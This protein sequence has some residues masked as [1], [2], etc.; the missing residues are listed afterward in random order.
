MTLSKPESQTVPA[1]LARALIAY[2]DNAAFTDADLSLTYGQL[3]SCIERLQAHLPAQ[4]PVA[5]FGKPATM[6]A[7]AT[8]AC[9]VLGRPF[10]HLDPAMPDDVLANILSELA[11][12]IVFACQ[13]PKDGQLPQGC[14][15]VDIKAVI[16]APDDTPDQPVKAAS[17]APD[18]V[19]Y[20]VATSGTTGKP[21]C[22]PVTQ[23]AAYLS[24]MWR[25]AYTPYVAGRSV[26]A[27]IFAIWEMFRPLRNGARICFP[28][29]Q[30]L[31][32]PDDLCAFLIRYDVSEMLFTPS[33]LE[34]TLQAS[35]PQM[36]QNVPL[37]RIILNGEVVSDALIAAAREKLPKAVLWNLYSICETHDIAMTNVTQTDGARSTGAVGITMPHLRAIVLDDHDVECA[38]GQAGLLHFEGP[39][40]LGPGYVNRA[41]ETALRFRDLTLNGR[42]LRL[43][44][45]GDQGYVSSDGTLHILG[46]IAHMLKLRGHSIQTRDLTESLQGHLGFLQAV[47]WIKHV[48]GQ[49]NA[50]IFYY[51]ANT[52][53]AN[54]NLD[55]WGLTLGENRMPAALSKVLRT[56]LPAYCV[57]SFLVALDAIPINA[58]SGKCDFKSLPEIVGQTTDD[59][60]IVDAI[61]TVAQAAQVLGC[62]VRDVD[63]ALS[64]HDQGGD[65]L[66]AVTLVLALEEAYGRR[67]DFDFALNVALARLHDVLTQTLT[68]PV[69]KGGFG[70]AGILLTGVTGFL[71]SR[72]LAAAARNLP[73]GEVIYCLVRPK[74]RDALERLHE[75]AANNGVDPKRLVLVPA[76]IE[77]ARFGLG[78]DDYRALCAAT[79]RVIHCAAMVNLAVDRDH[80][81]IWSKAGISNILQFCQDANADL[82]FSSSTAVYAD[83]GGPYAEAPTALF[84]TCGGYGAAKIDAEHLIAKSGVSAAIVRLPSLYDI[85]APN[86]ND[87]YETIM[88]A[89]A[90]LSAVPQGMTFRMIDVHGAAAFLAGLQTGT[91]AQYFNLTP[92]HLITTDD[93]PK[94]IKVLPVAVWLAQAPLSAGERALIAADL[95]VLHANSMFEHTA[96]KA[97]WTQISDQPFAKI[98]DPA[99]LLA[100]RFPLPK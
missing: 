56:A 13:T 98:S 23:D 95:T 39:R 48:A 59:A 87:I 12:D 26:G 93:L 96:A 24:Y 19:I 31:L 17:V 97:M 3:A 41:A 68:A 72:V 53:Q 80:M 2:S 9:V 10:V 69:T 64:F 36:M 66:M 57:P 86:P 27:Y 63:P 61:P 38:V 88:T 78:G 15:L 65:S 49:G 60:D 94:T 30:E 25:D 16:A 29:F 81:E 79:R 21:K 84:T 54:R 4:G 5:V 51:C 91:G 14:T 20:I 7:A 32:N 35:T 100:H 42:D 76:A 44:D 55:N 52:D 73:E 62:P 67:V 99:A 46:R 43:Y 40:M 1:Q 85:D 90:S 70:R 47:P 58:V 92:D 8:T 18:D 77:D 37:R 89:C 6:F 83:T 75:I 50:L 71:G 22:I 74:R 34:K 45:T 82:R 33:A 11:I 28:S